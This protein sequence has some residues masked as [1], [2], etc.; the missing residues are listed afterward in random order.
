MCVLVRVRFRFTSKIT[1]QCTVVRSVSAQCAQ[2]RESRAR[3]GASSPIAGHTFVQYYIFLTLAFLLFPIEHTV[4]GV[5]VC[6]RSRLYRMLH[7]RRR[8]GNRLGSCPQI[9]YTVPTTPFFYGRGS[10]TALPGQ[11]RR[12]REAST[13]RR[14]TPAPMP[15]LL[16]SASR[17]T[18]CAVASGP[19]AAARAACRMPHAVAA[20]RAAAHQKS[21]L[22]SSGREASAS[23]AI[24]TRR[25]SN[26]SRLGEA[27][28]CPSIPLGSP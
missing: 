11:R 9:L 2:R 12:G 4:P 10:T 17:P 15:P 14:A 20:G 7:C 23:K 13:P 6:A 8:E 16:A 3:V 1:F 28:S 26:P 19:R 25:D 27:M 24:C 21:C 18:A 22:Y 5:L